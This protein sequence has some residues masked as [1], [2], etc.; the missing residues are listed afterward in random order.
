MNKLKDKLKE[1]SCKRHTETSK[2]NKGHD[3]LI[4]IEANRKLFPTGREQTNEKLKTLMNGNFKNGKDRKTGINIRVPVEAGGD[5]FSG[6][7]LV[8]VAPP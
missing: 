1:N 2:L 8:N 6:E 5:P 7:R 3:H 4:S